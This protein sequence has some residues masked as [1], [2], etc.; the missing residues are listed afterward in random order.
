MSHTWPNLYYLASFT[1]LTG[2]QCPA[3]GVLF[4]F[5][6]VRFNNRKKLG[7]DFAADFL[8]F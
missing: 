3:G 8:N 5:E 7:G 4:A 1:D 2:P 6:A